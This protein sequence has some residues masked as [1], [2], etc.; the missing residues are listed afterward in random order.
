[1]S[2]QYQGFVVVNGVTIPVTG[3]QANLARSPI[4]PE[5]VWGGAWKVNYA[6]GHFDPKFTVN[7]PFMSAQAGV[8][9]A[10]VSAAG[11]DAFFN[12]TICN[13]GTSI[14]Y[15]QGKCSGFSVSVDAMGNSPVTCS[16]TVDAVDGQPSAASAGGSAPTN[17]DGQTP[18]PSYAMTVTGSINGTAV[19]SAIITQ[20][21]LSIN[22]NPF[23][24]FTL[25]G[26]ELPTDVQL[27]LMVVTGSYTFY[28]AGA[29]GGAAAAKIGAFT[30]SGQGLNFSCANVIYTGDD[31]N[32]EGPNGKPMR[33]VSFEAVGTPGASPIG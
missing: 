24:L 10:M 27:G 33:R 6:T 17:V 18:V 16:L 23:K 20:A 7:F 31:N 14:A 11:R 4:I 21:E 15:T 12:A 5:V 29:A 8:L 28:S 13:G 25:N 1:M 32:I 3:A 30:L 9:N 2:M 26:S 22:N 19:A